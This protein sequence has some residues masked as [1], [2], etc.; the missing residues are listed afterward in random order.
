M[1]GLAACGA[2]PAVADRRGR[3]RRRERLLLGF[4]RASLL[5]S[6]VAYLEGRSIVRTLRGLARAA[7]G[8]AR[9]RFSERVPVRGRDEFAQLGGAFNDDGGA[10]S[11]LRLADLEAERDAAAATQIARFGEA[12]AATHDLDQLLRVI[13]DGTVEATGAAGARLTASDGT[14]VVAGDPE[15]PGERLRLS[16]AAGADELGHD[17]SRRA[18]PST[19]EQR[20]DR[21]LARNAR[22]DRARQRAAPPAGRAAGARRRAHRRREP[23][24]LRGGVRGRDRARRPARDAARARPRRPRRLQGGERHARPRRRRRGRCGRS[25]RV[26]RETVRESDLAGRWGGEE[27]LLLLPG[28]GSEGAAQLA[29]R[30]RLALAGDAGLRRRTGPPSRSPRAS[31]SPPHREGADDG[32]LYAAADEALY[33]A[34]AAGKDRVELA[35]AV[36]S[37]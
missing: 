20:R 17:R 14:V 5:V 34:K 29:E 24:P 26:L 22:G 21:C 13:V 32:T 33:R 28:T 3:A 19:T 11:R 8:I 12:L 10:S 18:P 15:A 9:G 25:P 7:N 6:V 1:P 36:R 31:A 4:S 2:Q 23:A 35:R 30:I 37:F 16:L 27:F